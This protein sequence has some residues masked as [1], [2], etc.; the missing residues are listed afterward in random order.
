MDKPPGTQLWYHAICNNVDQVRIELNKGELVDTVGRDGSTPL[1]ANIRTSAMKFQI[2]GIKPGNQIVKLLLQKGAN[3]Q[4]M[5][6]MGYC[7][8]HDCAVGGNLDH[9]KLLVEYNADVNITTREKRTPLHISSENGHVE[10]S[11]YLIR[12]RAHIDSLDIEDR[13]PLMAAVASADTHPGNVEIVSHLIDH[14]ANMFLQ[15]IDGQTVESLSIGVNREDLTEVI[16]AAI[17]IKEMCL[18][19]ASASIQRL[20]DGSVVHQIDSL[21][22]KMIVHEVLY[23]KKE[24]RQGE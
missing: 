1:Q 15:G 2:H 9:L 14:G 6:F 8:I 10:F 17:R 3:L 19:F 4:I 24:K 12:H 18:A 13:T 7:A 5:N 21:A 20:G 16:K 11:K 23:R 22:M